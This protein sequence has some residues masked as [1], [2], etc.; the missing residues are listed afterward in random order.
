MQELMGMPMTEPPEIQKT[1]ETEKP[2]RK[3]RRANT[4]CR[5]CP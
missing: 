1:T 3:I 2:E 5:G 4:A